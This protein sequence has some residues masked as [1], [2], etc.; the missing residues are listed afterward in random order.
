MA[1]DFPVS[2]RI[3]GARDAQGRIARLSPDALNQIQKATERRAQ[4]TRDRF[5]IEMAREYTSQWATGQLA[6]GITFKTFKKGNGVQIQF[7][8]RDRRELRFVTAALGGHFQQFP[9]G[10]FVIKANDPAGK[11]AI[12]LPPGGHTRR[13]LRG[14]KGKFA[15]SRAGNA[16]IVKEVLWGN[17]SGGFSRDVISEVAEQEGALFVQDVQNAVGIAISKAT[18]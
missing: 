11:L 5:Q 18:G 17:K 2:V 10:P 14:A 4:I 15:G 1:L 3:V 12:R 9:V 13:F 6:R 7:F 8:I 16:I